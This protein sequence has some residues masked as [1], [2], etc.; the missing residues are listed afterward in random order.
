L[1]PAWAMPFSNWIVSGYG[2]FRIDSVD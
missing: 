1:S 2:R